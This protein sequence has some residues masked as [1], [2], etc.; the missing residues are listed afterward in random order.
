MMPFGGFTAAFSPRF[1]YSPSLKSG[2]RT[3]EPTRVSGSAVPTPRRLDAH[4]LRE[5]RLSA[6]GKYTIMVGIYPLQK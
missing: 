5:R 3:N 2:W 6:N 1:L 4:A